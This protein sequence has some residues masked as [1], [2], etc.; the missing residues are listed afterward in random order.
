MDRYLIES[1][2]DAKD[3]ARLLQLVRAM[4]YLYNFDWG[5]KSGVHCGW[6]IVEAESEAH[7]LMAVPPMVRARARIIRLNKFSPEEV[8]SLHTD[9]E[10]IS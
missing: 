2:H 7:A 8:S 3:C 4:G 1:P 6:A 10:S 5:C 9:P